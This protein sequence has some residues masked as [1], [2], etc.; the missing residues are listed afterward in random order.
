MTW[1]ALCI[2]PEG[3][4]KGVQIRFYM[5]KLFHDDRIPPEL[6]F[7]AAEVELES[8]ADWTVGPE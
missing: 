8:D 1:R 3:E 7:N 2:S 4:V 5:S 6:G